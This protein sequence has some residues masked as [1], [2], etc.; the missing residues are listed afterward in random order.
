MCWS[1]ASLLARYTYMAFVGKCEVMPG[2]VTSDLLLFRCK[3][4]Q[5]SSRHSACQV[6]KAR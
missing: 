2:N 3:S 1:K 4:T 5:A 6:E